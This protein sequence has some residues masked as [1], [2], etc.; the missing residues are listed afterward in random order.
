MI[1]T[2]ASEGRVL[3]I[4]RSLVPFLLYNRPIEQRLSLL[5]QPSQTAVRADLVV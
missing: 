3:W 5:I 1:L 2:L 4:P